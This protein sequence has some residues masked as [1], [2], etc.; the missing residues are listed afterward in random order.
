[1]LGN[2]EGEVRQLMSDKLRAEQKAILDAQLREQGREPDDGSGVL[3]RTV[4]RKHRPVIDLDFPS[5]SESTSTVKN[6]KGGINKLLNNN[7]SLPSFEPIQV[8]SASYQQAM[9]YKSSMVQESTI[10]GSPSSTSPR[11]GYGK[12][13]SEITRPIN[14]DEQQRRLNQREELTKSLEDQRREHEAKKLIEKLQQ[15]DEEAEELKEMGFTASGKGGTVGKPR[16]DIPADLVPYIQARNPK[17]I[18]GSRFGPPLFDRL[19]TSVNSLVSSSINNH[20]AAIVNPAVNSTGVMTALRSPV[21]EK[22]NNKP[23]FGRNINTNAS[24]SASGLLIAVTDPKNDGSSYGNNYTGSSSGSSSVLASSAT[25]SQ[26]A[27]V[28]AK[29][30][31]ILSVMGPRMDNTNTNNID[32]VDAPFTLRKQPE[33]DDDNEENQNDGPLASFSSTNKRNHVDNQSIEELTSIVRELLEEQRQ[34]RETIAERTNPMVPVKKSSNGGKAGR[35]ISATRNRPI[36]RVPDNDNDDFDQ[37]EVYNDEPPMINS[38]GN[39]LPNGK[40]HSR[41]KSASRV[42]SSRRINDSPPVPEYDVPVARP[43]PRVAAN[44]RAVASA[45]KRPAFGRHDEGKMTAAERRAKGDERA[46]AAA[47]RN[48]AAL[49]AFR[50]ERLAAKEAQARERAAQKELKRQLPFN[51]LDVVRKG[52]EVFGGNEEDIINAY[53]SASPDNRPVHLPP[54]RKPAVSPVEEVLLSNKD[55]NL[56]GRNK[57]NTNNSHSP[58]F[59]EQGNTNN[60][61]RKNKSSAVVEQQP[62]INHQNRHHHSPENL[63]KSPILASPDALD[64]HMNNQRYNQPTSHRT[65]PGRT[66]KWQ[67]EA[68][69]STTGSSYPPQQEFHSPNILELSE[70]AAESRLI[71]PSQQYSSPPP[72]MDPSSMLHLSVPVSS[73]SSASASPHSTEAANVQPLHRHLPVPA[74]PHEFRLHSASSSPPPVFNHGHTNQRAKKAGMRSALPNVVRRHGGRSSAG[75][76]RSSSAGRAMNNHDSLDQLI[77]DSNHN[78]ENSSTGS[79][80]FAPPSSSGNSS[81]NPS[82]TNSRQDPVRKSVTTV[83][84]TQQHR[85]GIL[86]LLNDNK[87]T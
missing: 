29:L 79:G 23:F 39:K 71:F 70:L 86:S 8:L 24:S 20:H 56:I 34:L 31:R 38:Y 4:L 49:E 52:A 80:S 65:S 41:S 9:P 30:D 28:E 53:Q 10:I 3:P 32:T 75:P 19:S 6:S 16:P 5:T 44:G 60:N 83:T 33:N 69:V 76:S 25:A 27:E 67:T 37:D 85:G 43:P 48:A 12:A 14:E 66:N 51:R 64:K 68:T 84:A 26:L 63:R 47:Q 36:L 7:R 58:Q 17:I 50:L 78:F 82:R 59:T 18:Q 2:W 35:S 46:R 11:R 74:S 42:P 22:E 21:V 1:M 77:V 61:G 40:S 55:R 81:T 13:L 72:R 45:P 87:N 15:W 73:S 62:P 57:S 54:K